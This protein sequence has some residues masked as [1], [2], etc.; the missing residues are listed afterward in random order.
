MQNIFLL[1]KEE[2]LRDTNLTNLLL[3][4][5]AK[6]GTYEHAIKGTY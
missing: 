1:G 3:R 5:L 4:I 2:K 6:I